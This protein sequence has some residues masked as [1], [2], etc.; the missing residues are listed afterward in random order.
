MSS[1]AA[2]RVVFVLL[3]AATGA[4][5]FV[6]QK[7]KTSD[8]VVKRLALQRF[9]SPN[10]DGRKESAGI[11]F[12]LP[13]GD[14]VTVDVVNAGGDR[15]R[16]LTDGR[17][18]HAGTHSQ[19]WDGRNDRGRVAPDGTY[20][21]RVSLRDQGRAITGARGIVLTTRAPRAR[22]VSARPG[23][24]AAARRVPVTIRFTGP[25]VVRPVFRVWR[26]DGRVRQVASFTVPR[27]EHAGTW[28]GT[29]G[30]RPA[31]EGSYAF[32]VT[33]RNRALVEGS[34]PRRLPPT[35]SEA[36]PGTGVR[37]AG[38]EPV[39]PIEAVAAGAVAKIPLLGSTGTL[40]WRLT[41]VGSNHV[42]RRGT[43][44][45]GQVAFRIPRGVPAGEYVVR[46]AA[47]RRPLHV[48]LTVR[49]PTTAKVL[50]VVPAIAWQGRN[51]VDDDLDGFADTLDVARSVPL[52]RPLA[53][54][55][56]PARFGSQIEPLLGFL[57]RSRLRY[58]ID[59]D[60][61]LARQGGAPDLSARSGVLLAGDE[62]W[63]PAAMGRA[64]R[65]YVERGGT[66]VSLGT[67][68]LRRQVVLGTGALMSPTGPAGESIFGEDTRPLT[69]LLAPLVATQDGL[70]L[71]TGTDGVVGLFTRFE[72]AERPAT[73]GRLLVN[74]GR[75]PA[76]P[77]F[78]AYRF[79][80]GL[81]IRVGTPEWSRSLRGRPEAA[82]VMRRIW[83]RLER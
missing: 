62:R 9:F 75:D 13:K 11:S 58:D 21:V 12:Q 53:R 78:A 30:G 23:V 67:D 59:T 54:G 14:R 40:P 33:V 28:D 45:G 72:Q 52:T 19:T 31:P 79:G 49:K 35:R 46:I 8:P 6:T 24:V 16:R 71:F 65:G 15:V 60:V 25:A 27:G 32:S 42:L 7:L 80:R 66:V 39:L 63:L 17:R 83:T 38:P 37:I 44:R 82:A 56:L 20:Y 57:Q 61:G 73:G 34:A 47:G 43:D 36:R 1:S 2:A 76:K 48:P 3:V 4:A 77:A 64:L 26:T 22:L 51:P 55:A 74:A 50:V 81:F 10:G 69:S 18:L 70:G 41:R 29:L 68:S 5:F